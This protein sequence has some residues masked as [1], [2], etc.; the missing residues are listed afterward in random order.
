MIESGMVF[1]S[2]LSALAGGA[3][4][5]FWHSRRDRG[6]EIAQSDMIENLLKSLVT[7]SSRIGELQARLDQSHE[8][9]VSAGKQSNRKHREMVK[10]KTEEIRAQIELNG[11]SA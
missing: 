2:C 5:H 8:R 10:A 1:A 9:H 6:A 4:M 11:G 3:A 7:G